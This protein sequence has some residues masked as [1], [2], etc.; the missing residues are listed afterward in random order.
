MTRKFRKRKVFSPSP[1]HIWAA[2]LVDMKAFSKYN[3]GYKYIL[4]IMDVHSRY[5]Y[6]VPLKDKTGLSV[7]EALKKIFKT[8]KPN[9]LWTDKGKEFYNKHV[10]DLIEVYST[11]N[12]EKASIIERFNRTMKE[13]MFKYFTAKETNKY[14]DILQDLVAEYNETI[15]SSIGMTPSEAR[16]HGVPID[17]SKEHQDYKEPKLKLGDHVRLSKK[18]SLF[19]KGYTTRWTEEIFVITK[20]K[21]TDPVTYEVTDLNGEPIKGSFYEQELQKTTQEVFR[22][23]KVLKRKGSKLYVKW[24]NYGPEFNSWIDESNLV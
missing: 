20:V 5:G 4:T 12:E 10:Q 14:I 13:K 15:H 7:S 2:D 19:E 23:E 11:E 3:N 24:L 9:K 17:Y 1:D 21:R 8:K 16:E 18:K 22:I 6:M